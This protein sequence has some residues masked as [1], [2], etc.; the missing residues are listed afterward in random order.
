MVEELGEVSGFK[1]QVGEKKMAKV[2][3][4]EELKIWQIAREIANDET[5]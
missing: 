1:F 5:V 4:F 3:K 2:Q